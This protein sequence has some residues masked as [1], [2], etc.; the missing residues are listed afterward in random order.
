M[1][2]L[3]GQDKDIPE[4][5][6]IVLRYKQLKKKI[7][8]IP[9]AALNAGM[10]L[11]STYRRMMTHRMCRWAAAL[12]SRQR[13]HAT[14]RLLLLPQPLQTDK[15]KTSR[16]QQQQA[17]SSKQRPRFWCQKQQQQQHARRPKQ[18]ACRSL[19][20]LPTNHPLPAQAQGCFRWRSR[21]SCTP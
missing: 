19:R 13:L 3:E 1:Q 14:M 11:A 17:L 20:Q 4:F 9:K 5:K 16:L 2:V 7:K 15:R 6:H 12:E 10:H 18:Q 21:T 8:A